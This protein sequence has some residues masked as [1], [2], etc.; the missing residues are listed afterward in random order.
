MNKKNFLICV[1]LMLFALAG[2]SQKQ[3]KRPKNIILMVGDGM[4]VSHHRMR[5][6]LAPGP[7]HAGLADRASQ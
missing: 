4:G 2:Y 1:L 5:A 6:A 3:G 7:Q